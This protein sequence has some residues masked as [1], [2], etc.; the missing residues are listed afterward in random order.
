MG[1][2]STGTSGVDHQ[3]NHVAWG[4][5]G[6][7]GLPQFTTSM[8]EGG[9]GGQSLQCGQRPYAKAQKVGW[10]L[11]GLREQTPPGSIL[12]LMSA[13]PTGQSWTQGWRGSQKRGPLR[14]SKNQAGKI[15]S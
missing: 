13:L 5:A 6:R 1:V 9:S 7:A 15:H 12:V 11:G 8:R 14:C 2:H 10:A 4:G 3:H